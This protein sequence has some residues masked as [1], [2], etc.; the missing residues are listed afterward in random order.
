L[1]AI[2]AAVGAMVNQLSRQLKTS[3]GER[4]AK[5]NGLSTLRE[6]LLNRLFKIPFA[7]C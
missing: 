4:L 5:K 2:T 1:T 7:L 3:E 6:V